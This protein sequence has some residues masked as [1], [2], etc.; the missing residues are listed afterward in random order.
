MFAN[1]NSRLKNPYKS[2]K[3]IR[4]KRDFIK[5]N[6]SRCKRCGKTKAQLSVHHKIQTP[7]IQLWEYRDED[8]VVACQPCHAY[9]HSKAGI[10]EGWFTP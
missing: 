5:R 6:G 3:W 9:M 2:S 10:K 7:N 8:L 1:H 4:F